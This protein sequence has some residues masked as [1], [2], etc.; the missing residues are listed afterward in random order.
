MGR[1]RLKRSRIGINW[2]VID[3]FNPNLPVQAQILDEIA[4]AQTRKDIYRSQGKHSWKELL[5]PAETFPLF[6]SSQKEPSANIKHRPV[7]IFP[8]PVLQRQPS[9]L[10]HLK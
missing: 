2:N 10:L 9:T 4:L 5:Q 6:D 7:I 8:K 3:S 1:G